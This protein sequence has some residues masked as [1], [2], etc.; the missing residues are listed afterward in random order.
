M[1]DGR[2]AEGAAISSCLG[3]CT[4]C[5]NPLNTSKMSMNPDVKPLGLV[6]RLTFGSHIAK[7]SLLNHC[8]IPAYIAACID[9]PTSHDQARTPRRNYQAI[10]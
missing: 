10:R 7:V 3:I 2:K 5:A 4:K 6:V 9:S 1:E 8:G